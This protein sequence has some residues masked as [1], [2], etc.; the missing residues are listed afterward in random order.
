MP[1]SII[2]NTFAGNPLDRDS[3]R[4]GDE[5]FLAEKLADPESLAVALWNG[6]SLIHI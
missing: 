1:L 5:A 3:E 4:R 2:T 6:L